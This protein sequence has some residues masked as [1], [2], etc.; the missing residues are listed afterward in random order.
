MYLF[1]NIFN[2]Y[3]VYKFRFSRY[4]IYI[5]I[6]S[7]LGIYLIFITRLS[8][9]PNYNTYTFIILNY[10]TLYYLY[11][12]NFY[13]NTYIYIGVK[14]IVMNKFTRFRHKFF[15]MECS[16]CCLRTVVGLIGLHC[17]SSSI[18]PSM[19]SKPLCLPSRHFH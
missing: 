18:V 6:S 19:R 15:F 1:L 13:I 9:T 16:L 7:Y 12:Y 14:I 10:S 3:Y 8:I 4:I 5:Y 2:F 11:T 17:Y